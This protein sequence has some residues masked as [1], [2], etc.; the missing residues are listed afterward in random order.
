MKKEE[1]GSVK[2]RWPTIDVMRQIYE[3]HLWGGEKADFYSGDGSHLGVIVDPYIKEV[4]VFLKSFKKPLVIC[5][6]GCGDFN[7]GRQLVEFSEKYFAVD[8]VSALI[9]RNKI[10]FKNDKL[11]FQCLDICNDDLPKADCIFVRQVLQHLSNIEI[12]SF[13]TQLKNYTYC[14]VTEH[15]PNG[16]YEPNVD[17]VTSMGNRLKKKSGVDLMAHPFNFKPIASYELLRI[18][19]DDESCI[20][21]M[22]YQNF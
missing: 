13:L 2:K 19:L 20:Q 22:V 21:T 14:I 9:E 10:K 3:K 17:V 7:I 15:I 1:N 5:D 16:H 11:V 4:S 18:V 6:V 12:Q 8:I